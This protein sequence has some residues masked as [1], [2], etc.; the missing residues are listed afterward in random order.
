MN[1][2]VVYIKHFIRDKATNDVIS[3]A[4]LIR[5]LNETIL[6]YWIQEAIADCFGVYLLGP[7]YIFSTMDIILN[8]TGY[9][10]FNYDTMRDLVTYSHPPDQLRNNF[11]FDLL[12]DLGLVEQLD[13]KL[14]ETISLF[15]DDLNSSKTIAVYPNRISSYD[16]YNVLETKE[17]Y[18]KIIE[19]WKKTLP[20]VKSKVEKVLGQ[21]YMKPDDLILAN[22]LAKE[23]LIYA[24]PPNEYKGEPASTRSILNAGWI[25]RLLYRK[26]ISDN[27]GINDA[28]DNADYIFNEFLNNLLKYALQTSRI[29]R[30]WVS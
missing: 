5:M 16:N 9:Y 7:A 22:Q 26:E 21:N 29:H 19:L 28:G 17:F 23:K 4:E 24:V 3:Q 15:N 20:S 27:M 10:M 18:E 14:K 6:G 1:G 11:Q 30:R 12:K 2:F 8:Y 13:E 25:A